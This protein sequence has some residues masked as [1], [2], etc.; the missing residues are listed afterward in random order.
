MGI[1]E[2]IL[3]RERRVGMKKGV[4]LGEKNATYKKDVAFT[5]SLLTQT[6]FSEEKIAVLV[7]VDIEFVQKVKASLK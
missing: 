7:G 3:D 2:F 6:D 4:E 5:K 1:E